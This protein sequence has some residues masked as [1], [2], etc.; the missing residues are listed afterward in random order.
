M[1][2]ILS[3]LKGVFVIVELTILQQTSDALERC[4]LND[5]LGSVDM[6]PGPDDV[7]PAQQACSPSV[8]LASST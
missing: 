6:C 3:I 4:W 8:H 5:R 1:A 2:I 7:H